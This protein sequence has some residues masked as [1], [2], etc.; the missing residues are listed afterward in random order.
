M[1]YMIIAL[2]FFCLLLPEIRSIRVP[3]SMFLL[4]FAV[5]AANMFV[6]AATSTMYG[7]DYPLSQSAYPD[8]WRGQVAF[9]P[10]LARIGVRG[11]VPALAIAAMCVL[12]LGF[13]VPQRVP[14]PPP[15]LRTRTLLMSVECLR[16]NACSS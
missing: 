10:L 3:G 7:S 15:E 13:A 11:I 16:R 8:F 4:L 5:S 14:G 9:N 1:R 2:P 6:L 12:A